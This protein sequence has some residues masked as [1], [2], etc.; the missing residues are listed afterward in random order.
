[1]PA[2]QWRGMSTSGGE[3]VIFWMWLIWLESWNISRAFEPQYVQYVAFLFLPQAAGMQDIF[4]PNLAQWCLDLFIYLFKVT[5]ANSWQ[6]PTSFGGFFWCRLCLLFKE[7][8]CFSFISKL[9]W[10]LNHIVFAGWSPFIFV[11]SIPDKKRKNLAFTQPLK[12]LLV[13]K[14]G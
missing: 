13:P 10:D 2:K 9:H 6:P 3:W 5:H 4:L 14:Y 12:F 7:E 1:M 8:R 11:F